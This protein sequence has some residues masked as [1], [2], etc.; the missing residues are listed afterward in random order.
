MLKGESQ[1]LSPFLL[2]PAA[3]AQELKVIG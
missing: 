1:K 2:T 3:D